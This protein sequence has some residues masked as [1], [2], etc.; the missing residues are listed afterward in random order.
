MSKSLQ[1][2]IA[3]TSELRSLPTTSMRLTSLLGDA[4][5]GADEVLAVIEKDPS[6]T[7]NLLKLCNSAFYGLRGQV[8]T[9]RQALVMLGNQTIVNL[10]FAA[11]MGD[12]LRGPLRG[13]HLERNDLWHHALAV[14]L[15]ASHLS[16]L[17]GDVALREQAFTA[18]LVHD[19]GKL[20][21][22]RALGGVL[23]QL[24]PTGDRRVMQAAEVDILGFDHAQAGAALGAAWNLPT[25]LVDVIAAHHE[26]DP[27]RL[28]GQP[29]P[30][31]TGT[32]ARAV[33]SA[34]L[35]AAGCGIGGGDQGAPE[36]ELF[37]A[38]AAMGFEEDVIAE[39]LARLPRDLDAMLAVI[40]E[41]R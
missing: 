17:S 32:L 6:L 21:L 40:G 39:L 9:A 23:V 22:D 14:A 16:S 15:G 34:D 8:S 41:S 2:L 20:L 33:A 19:I 37:G 12:V 10:A 25:G 26:S 5:V 7:T 38:T 30:A 27:G 13:Y 28:L 18:G 31:T 3:G 36:N 35:V 4:T 24:P 11:S 1:D 29:L